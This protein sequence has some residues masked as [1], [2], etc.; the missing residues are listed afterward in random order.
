MVLLAA[1]VA[2]IKVIDYLTTRQAQAIVADLEGATPQETTLNVARWVATEFKQ[3]VLQ[4]TWYRKY[5]FV[6][7]HRIMPEFLRLKRGSLAL[8]Y[9]DGQCSNMSWVL[10]RLYAELGMDAIQHDWIGPRSAHSALSVKLDG[11]WAWVDPFYGYAFEENER[12]ISLSRLQELVSAGA[13][14][15]EYIIALSD[16][17]MLRV[18]Q[19][20]DGVSHARDGDPLDVRIDL[21]LDAGKVVVGTLD[22]QW[23]DVLSQG[24]RKGLTS[25]LHY[26]GPRY[27]RYFFFRFT[28]DPDTAPRGFRIVFHLLDE[29][30]PD[31]L[32]ESNVPA[33]LQENKLIYETD[34]PEEG[35]RLSYKNMRWTLKN[36][37]RQRSW[38]NVDMVEF[39]PL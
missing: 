12:L 29:V 20:V 33:R 4:P 14:P 15:E 5:G 7:S 3:G 22:G 30:D 16:K 19:R 36:L 6:L 2:G 10:Q 8:L 25:H 32:P 24:A 28:A 11:E 35:I 37:L 39:V 13:D 38:Y 9:M 1:P 31:N 18:Y 26:V 27:S 23:R 17:P 34:D 21:P